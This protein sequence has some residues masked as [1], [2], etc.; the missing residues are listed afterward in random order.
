M[1]LNEDILYINQKLL[2]FAQ[3]LPQCNATN[4]SDIILMFN[5]IISVVYKF[6]HIRMCEYYKFKH[7]TFVSNMDL[8]LSYIRVV[9]LERLYKSIMRMINI[10][11][12]LEDRLSKILDIHLIVTQNKIR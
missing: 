7:N 5:D 8:S 1:N 11:V 6:I 2:I 3:K 10:Y 12:F 4:T 9:L